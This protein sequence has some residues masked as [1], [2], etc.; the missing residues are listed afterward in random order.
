[1]DARANINACLPHG[2]APGMARAPA[3]EFDALAV[4]DI[5]KKTPS[6][7]DSQPA[8]RDVAKDLFEVNGIPF[9]ARIRLADGG[10]AERRKS[11]RPREG[12]CG[13]GAVREYARQVGPAVNG[14]TIHRGGAQEKQ[15]YADI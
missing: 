1:M 2:H 12:R 15:R 14:V 5:F 9:L 8:G 7:A 10:L 3:I 6:I 4:V 11:R 13:S